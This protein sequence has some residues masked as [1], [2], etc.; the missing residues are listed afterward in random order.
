MMS[1]RPMF[2]YDKFSLDEWQDYFRRM[3]GHR[4]RVATPTEIWFRMLE[5]IGELVQVARPPDLKGIEKALPDVFA[6]LL[7]FCDIQGISLKD[8]VGDRF[9]RGCPYCGESENCSCIYFPDKAMV[10]R[11]QEGFEGPLFETLKERP[12]EDWIKAFDR[13]YGVTNR[14]HSLVDIVS[15]LV[16]SAGAVAKALRAKMSQEE[17]E[18]SVANLFA[19]TVGVYTK[20]KSVIGESCK[21]FAQLVLEKYTLCPKCRNSVCKCKPRVGTVFIGLVAG[22]MFDEKRGIAGAVER[23]G[24]YPEYASTISEDPP[25]NYHVT[26]LRHARDNDATV[27]ILNH[28]VTPYLMS[29]FYQSLLRGQPVQVFAR[30]PCDRDPLLS[31]FLEEVGN[32]DMITEFRDNAELTRRLRNWLKTFPRIRA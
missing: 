32:A 7:A 29:L 20:Y 23:E 27:L 5:E 16:E 17:L 12:L 25:E 3:Y 9:A 1:T 13:L 28:T 4:N 21:T 19:W 11:R 10:Q 30:T 15:H 6:W 31:S 24:A 2:M 14:S 26:L 8:A 22:D 18:I